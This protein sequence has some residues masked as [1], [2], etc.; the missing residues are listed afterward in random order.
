M[1]SD[2]PFYQTAQTDGV[3]IVTVLDPELLKGEKETFYGL[4]ESLAADVTSQ[5]VVLNLANVRVFQSTML[6]VMINFQKRLKEHEK[7]LRLCSVDSQVLR[8]FQLTK[9]DQIFDIQ[10][11]ESAAIQSIQGKLGSGWL[12]KLRGMFGNS[13]GH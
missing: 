4:A 6:G 11:N 5:G 2:S 1:S 3:S 7:G 12:S 8:V 10:P 13:H 9:M